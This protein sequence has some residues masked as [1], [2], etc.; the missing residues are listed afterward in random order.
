MPADDLAWDGLE[1]GAEGFEV[2]GEGERLG[3]CHPAPLAVPHDRRAGVRQLLMVAES[4]SL[5]EMQRRVV[6]VAHAEKQH[7]GVQRVEP[8]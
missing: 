3:V 4:P 6:V 2:V 7:F 1:G 8:A 5:R